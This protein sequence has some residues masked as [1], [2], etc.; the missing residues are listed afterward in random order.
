MHV[1]VL[2]T[3]VLFLSLFVAKAQDY[4]ITDERDTVFCNDLDFT[5]TTQ[6]WLSSIKYKGE[7]GQQITIKGKDKL[8]NVTT[9]FISGVSID[10]TPLKANKPDS[11]IRYDVR[12]LDGAI[13]VYAPG[14]NYTKYGDPEGAYRFFVRFPDGTF[15]EVNKKNMEAVFKPFFAA[16]SS[17]MSSYSGSYSIK[18]DEAIKMF[19][20]YNSLCPAE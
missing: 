3:T 16:C 15:Y 9:F 18:E 13:R 11:Y 10:K 6:G 20:L 7:D 5:T 12:V 4:Y 2:F 14:Q 17:F 8:P 19:E 1:K